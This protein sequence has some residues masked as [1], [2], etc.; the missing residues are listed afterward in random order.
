MVGIMLLAITAVM[1]L[2]RL[3][4]RERAGLVWSLVAM[5]YGLTV[6]LLV[7]GFTGSRAFGPTTSPLLL[8]GFIGNATGILSSMLAAGLTIIGA[9]AARRAAVAAAAT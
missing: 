1:P 6:G 2:L 5:G 9:H 7:E 3:E 4:R 8:I